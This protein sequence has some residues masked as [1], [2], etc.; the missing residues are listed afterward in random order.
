MEEEMIGCLWVWESETD[1][2][3]LDGDIDSLPELYE[4]DEIRFE[5]NQWNQSRSKVSCTIFSA[6]WV[7]AD[8][9]NYNFSLDEIKEYDEES[10]KPEWWRIRGQWRFTKYAFDL[11][12]KKYNDSELSKKYGKVAYYRISKNSEESIKKLL[13]KKYTLWTNWCITTAYQN[14]YRDDAFVEWCKFWTQTNGHAFNIISKKWQRSVKD[15][16]SGRKTKDWKKDCNT[17]WLAHT[18]WEMT[19]YWLRLYTFTLV[20]EDSLEEDWLYC[21]AL[22][23]VGMYP[24]QCVCFFPKEQGTE[25]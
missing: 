19:N 3:L 4:K 13:D 5:W 8:L 22:P 6:L 1:Y 7:L 9:I 11:V 2:I 15:S 17:F 20:K 10:Y 14:D 24:F 18:V 23:I 25:P 12:C 21:S 16:Y